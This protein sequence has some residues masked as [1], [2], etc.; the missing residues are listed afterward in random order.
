M[1]KPF[2]RFDEEPLDEKMSSLTEATDRPRFPAAS[3]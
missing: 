1:A 2:N 3:P